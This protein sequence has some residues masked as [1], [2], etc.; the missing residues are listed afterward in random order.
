VLLKS[1]LLK[2]SVIHG[3]ETT[4]QVLREPGRA[5]QTKSY[6]WLYRTS[7][8]SE[9]K[10]VVFDYKETRGQEHPQKFLKDYNGFLHCDGYQSYHNLPFGIT[11]VGCWFH[12][13]SYFEKIL[14]STPKDKRSGTDEERGVAFINRLFALERDFAEL[15]P[16]ERYRQ[17]LEKSKPVSDAFFD[18]VDTLPA[19]P[20]S[21]LGE[22]VTYA[23][24]QKVYLNNIYLDG[25]LE[26]SNNKC[27]RSVKPFVQGRKVWLFSFSPEGA[28]ASSAMFSIFETAKENGLVP[29]QYM[30]FLLETIPNMSSSDNMEA[31]LP[32]S[33]SL[34][35]YC[36]TPKKPTK[37]DEIIV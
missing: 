23:K 20:K 6:E 18:W 30:K 12:V 11:I 1:Y 17:R 16:E 4:H 13:R 21:L 2:E 7:G 15:L 14:K 32:W 35:D 34:P 27:E 29:F 9:R 8:H 5:P 22:A 3:D 31:L 26:I 19:L 28:E 33:D 37:S 10:I 24:N 25:R 36:R